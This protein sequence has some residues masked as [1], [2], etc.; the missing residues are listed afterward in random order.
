MGGETRAGN[1]WPG[2]GTFCWQ[3]GRIYRKRRQILQDCPRVRPREATPLFSA[4]RGGTKWNHGLGKYFWSA[5]PCWWIYMKEETKPSTLAGKLRLSLSS[6]TAQLQLQPWSEGIRDTAELLCDPTQH[7]QSQG[8]T[9]ELPQSKPSPQLLSSSWG[10]NKQRR[11]RSFVPGMS[12]IWFELQEMHFHP[13]PELFVLNKQNPGGFVRFWLTLEQLWL[14]IA[15][16]GSSTPRGRHFQRGAAVPWN[17][18]P[19][20]AAQSGRGEWA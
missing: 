15:G 7:P 19:G 2:F 9:P 4:G 1:V 18:L 3:H 14:R 16:S 8:E 13:L 17:S 11:S 20:I 10:E 12:H 5:P 6:G